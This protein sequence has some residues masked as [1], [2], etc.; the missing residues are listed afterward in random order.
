MMRHGVTSKMIYIDAS[1]EEDDVYQDL[2]DYYP[3]NRAGGRNFW[4]RLELGW[5]EVGCDALPVNDD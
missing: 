4:R 3:T 1:H 2:L 5:G